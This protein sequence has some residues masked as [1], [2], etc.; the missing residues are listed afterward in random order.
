M[1]KVFCNRCK[2]G[3]CPRQTRERQVIDLADG[4]AYKELYDVT[5]HEDGTKQYAVWSRIDVKT[6]QL[7]SFNPLGG[8][9]A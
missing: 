6:D 8:N 3:A 2:R 1:T 5:T 7:V 4:R 9:S